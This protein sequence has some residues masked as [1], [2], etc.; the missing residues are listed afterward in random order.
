MIYSGF[1]VNKSIIDVYLCAVCL[2]YLISLWVAN[3]RKKLH[4]CTYLMG[5]QFE[6]YSDQVHVNPDS[7]FFVC[8]GKTEKKKKVEKRK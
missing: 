3:N 8:L 4:D 1:A 6:Y 7:F 2:L 5:K